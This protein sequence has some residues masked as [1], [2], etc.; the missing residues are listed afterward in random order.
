M[1]LQTSVRLNMPGGIE[2]QIAESFSKKTRSF[3]NSVPEVITVSITAA[4]T[5]TTCTV[6]GTA[7]TANAGGGV[8]TVAA[9]ITEL[10]GLINAGETTVVAGDNTTSMSL[11]SDVGTD[12][13]AVGT[14]NCT[15]VQTTPDSSVIP[16]GRFVTVDVNYEGRA[17]LPTAATDITNAGSNAGIT[18][19]NN[20]VENDAGAGY[21]IYDEMEVVTQGVIYV[22]LEDTVTT[23]SSVYVRFVAGAG[24]ELGR[25]RGDADTA[26]AAILPNARFLDGGVAGELVRLEINMP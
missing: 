22:L 19:R 26:D 12:L 13:T 18:V 6:N 25:F 15:V 21:A 11:T 3:T 9:I 5:E 17:C 2:G 8:A 24:E 20:T 1:A 16:F 14:A 10:A 7:Y 4:D 23:A